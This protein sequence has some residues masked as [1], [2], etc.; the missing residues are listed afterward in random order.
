MVVV[1]LFFEIG[2]SGRCVQAVKAGWQNSGRHHG[3]S[4]NYTRGKVRM[5]KKISSVCLVLA[6]LV[7]AGG[8]SHGNSIFSSAFN[9]EYGM[10]LT[11]AFNCSVCHISSPGL[12]PYGTDYL[13]S[14]LSFLSIET[15]DS[16]GDGYANI[17]EINA[18]K[19]PGDPASHPVPSAESASPR[20]A[21][22]LYC[23]G[24][25]QSEGK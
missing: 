14:G 11:K 15:I 3:E 2:L 9:T 13:I 6:M 10:A 25:L 21:Q 17:A 7:G 22:P 20:E 24:Q 5:K 18:V 1:G 4:S 23:S 19:N 8:L 12:N 16:D